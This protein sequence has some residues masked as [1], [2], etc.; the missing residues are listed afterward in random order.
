M[1]LVMTLPD[2][3]AVRIPTILWRLPDGLSIDECRCL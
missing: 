3:I 1:G 2:D